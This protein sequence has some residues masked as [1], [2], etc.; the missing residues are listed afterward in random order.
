FSDTTQRSWYNLIAA[1]TG[2]GLTL[3]FFAYSSKP[4]VYG[5]A[6]WALVF[7]YAAAINARP[8]AKAAWLNGGVLVLTLGMVEMYFDRMY[9]AD[10]PLSEEEFSDDDR[11]FRKHDLLGFAPEKERTYSHIR[12]AGF[13][14]IYRVI[15][16][17][18]RRGL[19]LAP[20]FR[21]SPGHQTP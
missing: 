4:Y 1:I 19:R 10:E 7:F 16:T 5:A 12:R 18:D 8:W 11:L 3:G 20:P 17:I 13:E 15:Y 2:L 14:E 6:I 9:F 21:S